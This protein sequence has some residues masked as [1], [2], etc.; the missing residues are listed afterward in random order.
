MVPAVAV[1]DAELAPVGTVTDAGIVSRAL[2]SDSATTVA[3][4]ATWFKPTVQVVEMPE[5]TVAGLQ[6]NDVKPTGRAVVMV[7]PVAVMGSAPADGVAPNASV[8]PIEVAVVLG[9][10]VADTTATTPLLIIF[11]S[12]PVVVI[13]VRKQV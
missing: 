9:E 5:A 11:A 1:N 6:F 10:I 4:E 8:M 3:D 12:S 2:L 13:P 7:P